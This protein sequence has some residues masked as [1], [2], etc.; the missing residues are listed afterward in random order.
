MKPLF[1]LSCFVLIICT[2]A[3]AQFHTYKFKDSIPSNIILFENVQDTIVCLRSTEAGLE[4]NLFDTSLQLIAKK[5]FDPNRSANVLQQQLSTT[6]DGI[7]YVKQR[8]LN[9]SFDIAVRKLGLTTTD[10]IRMGTIIHSETAAAERSA[11]SFLY[12][13]SSSPSKKYMLLARVEADKAKP[14][15]LIIK[16]IVI[17]GEVNVLADDEMVIPFQTQ[18]KMLMGLF[19]NDRGHVE[20]IVGD[21]FKSYVLGTE[22]N[23]FIYDPENARQRFGKVKLPR[24]KLSDILIDNTNPEAFELYSTYAITGNSRKLIPIKGVTNIQINKNNFSTIINE[25]PFDDE[26]K[27]IISKILNTKSNTVFDGFGW[28]SSFNKNNEQF[29]VSSMKN[30]EGFNNNFPRRVYR[31]EQRMMTQV[32]NPLTKTQDVMFPS[33]Q[34]FSTPITVSN[35]APIGTTNLLTDAKFYRDPLI[36][37]RKPYR[38]VL[39]VFE[40][41]EKNNFITVPI[42][43]NELY[44]G[45]NFP[46]LV[47]YNG[48]VPQLAFTQKQ[49]GRYSIATATITTSGLDNKRQIDSTTNYFI[50]EAAGAVLFNNKIAFIIKNPSTNG[51][52]IVIAQ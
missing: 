35:A 24:Q 36:Q 34:I 49:K 23:F 42:S 21:K 7:F 14:D 19:I 29:V 16:F 9:N 30:I 10:S 28:E 15:S 1:L 8:I 40:K 31:P 13:I 39:V 33:Q 18:N 47:Y 50:D 2:S 3:G 26:A 46:K 41:A 32:I 38:E 6:T 43:D 27:K 44:D 12:R 4:W 45:L 22:L 17:D 48:K 5:I 25:L 52:A 37:V 51:S 11:L 20:C